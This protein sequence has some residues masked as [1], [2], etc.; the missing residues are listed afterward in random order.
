M[1]TADQW[2]EIYTASH[3]H[4]LNRSIHCACSP[5]ATLGLIGLLWS[6]PAPEAFAQISPALNWGSAFIMAAIVY[7]FITLGLGMIA[8]MLAM[9]AAIQ[10]IEGHDIALWISSLILLVAAF[11]GMLAGHQ[12]EGRKSQ[13]LV[14]LQLIMIAPASGLAA[15][16]RRV[17]ISY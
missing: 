1:R 10:W 4:P 2:F 6:A 13:L 11:G 8:V 9:V 5:L 12:L 3:R 14:D 16:Y 15:L 17:G 7:Y